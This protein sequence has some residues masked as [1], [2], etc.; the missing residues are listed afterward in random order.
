MG[1]LLWYNL[2]NI[3]PYRKGVSLMKNGHYEDSKKQFLNI[4]FRKPF[5]F[6]ARL[7]IALIHFLQK[8][9]DSSLAEYKFVSDNSQNKTEKFQAHFNSALIEQENIDS[10]LNFYQKALKEYPESI[11]VKT[12]IELMMKQQKSQSNKDKKS[13]QKNKD[14]KKQ[15]SPSEKENTKESQ[16]PIEEKDMS[17]DEAQFILKEIENRERKLRSRLENKKQGKKNKEGKKW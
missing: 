1:G 8:K 14:S 13:D 9:K 2:Q 6:S 17:F 15:N 5:L 12:N 7:N 3:Y 10:S 11:E 4:L 16:Q